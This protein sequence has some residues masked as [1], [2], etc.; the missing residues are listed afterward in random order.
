MGTRKNFP[1]WVP[2]QGLGTPFSHPP[3]HEGNIIGHIRGPGP[4]SLSSGYGEEETIHQF[5]SPFWEGVGL[6]F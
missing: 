5:R 4:A 1:G 2:Y 3:F 6:F